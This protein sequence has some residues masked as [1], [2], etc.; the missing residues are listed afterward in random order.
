VA[1]FSG[2]LL[3]KPETIME[4]RI[5]T[6][7]RI[8]YQFQSYGSINIVFIEVKLNIGSSTERLNFVAQVIA[9]CDGMVRDALDF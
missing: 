8:E 3:N 6:K 2:R 1:L 7:G 5:T 4:G 9:E